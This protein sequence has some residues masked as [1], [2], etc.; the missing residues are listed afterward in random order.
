MARALSGEGLRAQFHLAFNIEDARQHL[1]QLRPAVAVVDLSLDPMRGVES[2]FELQ[3]AI[4]EQAPCCRIIVLTGHGGRE[5]GIRA[6]RIGAASFL[7]KPAQIPHLAALI[8]D[9]LVQAELRSAYLSLVEERQRELG[10]DF[11]SASPRLK[12]VLEAIRYAAQT[13]QPVLITGETG[14]GKGVC[15]RL[16]H[17]LSRRDEQ[18]FIR[19][20]PGTNRELVGSD[21]FGHVKGAF[22]GALA[23]RRGLIGEADGGTLFLDELD[24]FPNDIQVALLGVLQ[25][26][27]FRRIG[28]SRE[29]KS[30]FRLIA[31]T[32]RDI[33]ACL[34]GGR[35]RTDL[36]HRIAHCRIALPPLR[37][38]LEDLRDLCRSFLERFCKKN[39][40]NVFELA[41]AAL[42]RLSDYRW[43]G[44]IR[45]LEAVVE[46]AAYR[47]HLGL[48][49]VI[50]ADDIAFIAGT[51]E[52]RAEGSLHE[53]L[54]IARRALVTEALSRHHGNQLRAAREL[55]IDRSTLRRIVARQEAELDSRARL[56]AES[57]RSNPCPSPK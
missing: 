43:P 56:A 6:L 3:Q 33:Q 57:E 29:E 23:E 45:E 30:D 31:A 27:T 8:R 54:N 55:R 46:G 47:A 14:V 48:R 9:G 18:R 41:P 4:V 52:A 49:T 16:I 1:C 32:N 21:L 44:N 53:R 38:R 13:N 10:A 50:E 25:D 40:A 51:E 22:T 11:S 5:F 35:I 26:R 17:S 2:G 24:E 37:E 15:A 12:S 28:S 36:Y 7:E 20:Q 19:Y 34:T 42:S 39:G